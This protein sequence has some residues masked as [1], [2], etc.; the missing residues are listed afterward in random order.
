MP[1]LKS[2]LGSDEFPCVYPMNL[3]I[4]SWLSL[5][6]VIEV[7]DPSRDL[8]IVYPGLLNG[9]DVATHQVHILVENKLEKVIEDDGVFF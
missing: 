3:L 9:F 8:G 4:I 2:I 7:V 5:V 1:Q 6:E